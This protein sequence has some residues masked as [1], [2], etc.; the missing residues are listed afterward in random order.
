MHE[1]AHWTFGNAYPGRMSGEFQRWGD[2]YDNVRSP[3][4]AIWVARG[5]SG[6]SL[7]GQVLGGVL[8]WGF[9]LPGDEGNFLNMQTD[10]WGT[11][12]LLGLRNEE[13]DVTH[14]LST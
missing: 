4:A 1:L 2:F 11:V 3:T 7:E 5:E 12:S 8:A 10:Q 13:R 6:Y 9:P 14:V